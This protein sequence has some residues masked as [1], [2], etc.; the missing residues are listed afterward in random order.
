MP[1]FKLK[2]TFKV[3]TDESTARERVYNYFQKAD[4]QEKHDNPAVLSFVRYVKGSILKNLV[5]EKIKPT[6]RY[7]SAKV[8]IKPDQDI[9]IVTI[10]FTD[11]YSTQEIFYAEQIIKQEMICFKKALYGNE[12]FQIEIPNYRRKYY[13]SIAAS[14]GVLLVTIALFVVLCLVLAFN[15]V[16]RMISQDNNI[17]LASTLIALIILYAASLLFFGYRKRRIRQQVNN[18]IV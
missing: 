16:N 17:L 10:T 5:T 11:T 12:F 14:I 18:Y 3:P 15:V 1:F 13:L 9:S 4:Y 6:T 7:S 2:M 8:L